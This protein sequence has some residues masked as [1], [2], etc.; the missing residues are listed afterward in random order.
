MN[1]PPPFAAPGLD[2]YIRE[3]LR[4][5]VSAV[6]GGGAE[7][8][9]VTHTHEFEAMASDG[10]LV[11]FS[12][13]AQLHP[14]VWLLTNLSSVVGVQVTSSPEPYGLRAVPPSQRLGCCSRELQEAHTRA[15]ESHASESWIS[16]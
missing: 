14:S 12:Y 11:H 4:G 1:D 8:E 16:A 7:A 5:S 15:V 10:R 9:A 3:G 13:Q 2:S 6:E